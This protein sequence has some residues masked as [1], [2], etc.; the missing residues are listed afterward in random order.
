MPEDAKAEYGVS[1]EHKRW[2]EE[3]RDEA[4]AGR[5]LHEDWQRLNSMIDTAERTGIGSDT[6]ELETLREEIEG[7]PRFRGAKGYNADAQEEVRR[8][9]RRRLS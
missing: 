2:A 1:K 7:D 8:R 6:S 9:A 5:E 3:V 4:N